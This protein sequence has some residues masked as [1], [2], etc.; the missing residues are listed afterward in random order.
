MA[1]EKMQLISILGKYEQ[2]QKTIDA[3][4]SFG[5]FQPEYATDVLPD[6]KGIEV[7]N[8]ENPYTARL[9]K[10]NEVFDY[11]GIKEE[12]LG[13]TEEYAVT[14]VDEV[15][16]EL[17][18]TLHSDREKRDEL[19]H[20][21][22][23]LE[24]NIQKLSHFENINVDMDEIF[25][26]QFIKVRFGRLPIES[27]EKIDAYQNKESIIFYPCV[28]E[29]EYCWGMYVAPIALID[30]ADRVFA[31]LFFERVI[32]PKE[33]GTPK[34]AIEENRRQLERTK[35]E[36]DN[37]NKKIDE[38]FENHKDEYTKLYSQLKYMS[39][40]FEISKFAVKYHE[41]F[42]M[43]GWVPLSFVKKFKKKLSAVGNLEIETTDPKNLFKLK[44]P[45]KLKNSRLVRPFQFLVEIYGLPSYSELDPTWF[46]ALTYTLLY[47]IMFADL[48]QGLVLSLVGLYMFR[49][50]KMALGKVLIPCGICSAFFG[51]V[52]GSVFGNEVLLNPM[53]YALGFKEKPIE[54]MKSATTLL[55]FSIGIGVALVIVA[56]ILNVASSFKQRNLESAIFSH[57]GICGIVFYSSI[58]AFALNIVLKLG[59]NTELLLIFGIV[60][61]VILIFLKVPLGQLV[62]SKKVNVGKVGDFIIENFFEMFE[63]ILSYMSN[64]LSF[65]RVGAFVLIHA[66]MMTTFNSLASITS[67]GIAGT[68]ILVF[69]NIFVIALE[70]TLVGI[71]VLRLEFYEMF[72]RFY[73][74]DGHKFTPVKVIPE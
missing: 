16:E 61:P 23:D 8:S 22:D 44:P 15:L 7:R 45:T 24:Q 19:Q 39:D 4:I 41:M 14:E 11:Y 55:V 3:C 34:E 40:A 28:V 72:S 74:G 1:V 53:F 10:L 9:S 63:V 70:G 54:V 48:G 31:S 71:Q 12:Y 26:S 6:F 51:L 59:I 20:K 73:N 2:L 62:S 25:N 35:A 17:Y 50:M 37:L 69:G 5:H 38:Y 57:N 60:I 56:M 66:G 13:A 46:V 36:L 29:D 64:T 18:K 49:K 43:F 58:I 21:V 42:I 33:H 30:E 32:V 52:F 68:I 47:G 67:G 65:L 27:V